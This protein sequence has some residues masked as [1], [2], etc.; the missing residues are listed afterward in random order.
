MVQGAG[1]MVQGAGCR[2]HGAG[3]RV[4]GAGYLGDSD[5]ARVLVG[6]ASRVVL[7][8][9]PRV[10]HTCEHFPDGSD[11]RNFRMDSSFPD[12]FD[13][14]LLQG[15]EHLGNSEAARV[16]VGVG[17]RVQGVGCKVQV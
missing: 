12:G 13:L 8:T 16:L 3:C 1:C 10:S 7:V 5:A 17:C 11:L 2:V 9:V 15:G 4:Q 14:Y 6:A